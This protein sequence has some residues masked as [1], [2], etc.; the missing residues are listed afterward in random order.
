MDVS[1]EIKGA[2]STSLSLGLGIVMGL[3]HVFSSFPSG[4]RDLYGIGGGVCLYGLCIRF[5][6]SVADHTL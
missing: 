1:T 4:I 6:I 5:G 2:M 3:C